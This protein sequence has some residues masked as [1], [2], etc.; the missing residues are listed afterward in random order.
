MSF[1]TDLLAYHPACPECGG[2][3]NSNAEPATCRC[4]GEIYIYEDE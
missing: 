2:E 4:C 3:V 1:Y